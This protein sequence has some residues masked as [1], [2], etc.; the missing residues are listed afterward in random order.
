MIAD[1]IIEA[2]DIMITLCKDKQQALGMIAI[3][4]M[5]EDYDEAHYISS[6]MEEKN[7]WLF[8]YLPYRA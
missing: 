8:E 2:I 7:N 6:T 1:E 4:E 3:K 5:L